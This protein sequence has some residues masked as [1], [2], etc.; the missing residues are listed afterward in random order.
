MLNN[1]IFIIISTVFVNNIAINKIFSL[2]SFM[3]ISKKLETSISMSAATAYV[4][5]IGS[6]TSWYRGIMFSG[7][8]N[9][10]THARYINFSWTAFYITSLRKRAQ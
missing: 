10:F 2:C 6:M 4:L 1:Q 3:A 7:K 9:L 8:P 5:I